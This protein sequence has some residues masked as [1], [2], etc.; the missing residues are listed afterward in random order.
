MKRTK[1]FIDLEFT[2]LTQGAEL[3]SLA[4]VSQQGKVFYA[5]I[6]DFDIDAS[7]NAEFLAQHVLPNLYLEE[8][9]SKVKDSGHY[10]EPNNIELLIDLKSETTYFRGPY[11]NLRHRLTEWLQQFTAIEIWGDCLAHDWVLFT[12]IFGGALEIPKNIY[13]IPFDICTIF[14]LNRIDPDINRELFVENSIESLGAVKH[15]AL[16]DAI[17][18][19]ACYKKLMYEE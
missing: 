8:R 16:S 17:I 12:E 1:I 14:K 3:I 5:E 4:L 10:T 7:K 9:F 19:G 15:N 6:T 18:I 13:Y 2:G 11:K